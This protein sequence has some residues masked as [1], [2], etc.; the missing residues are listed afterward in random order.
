VFG[1]VIAWIVLNERLQLMAVMG[2]LLVLASTLVVT[3][4]EER[5]NARKKLS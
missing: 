5:T 2:G 4:W 1:I 3:V